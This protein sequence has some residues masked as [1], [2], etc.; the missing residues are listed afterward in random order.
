[1]NRSMQSSSKGTNLEQRRGGPKRLAPEKPSPYHL[2]KQRERLLKLRE[3]VTKEVYQ[4][5][6]EACEEVPNYSMHMAD[7]ATDS[8][9]RDLVLGLASF[10]QEGL[11]EIDAALKR[12][13]DGTYGFC[14]LTGNPISWRRLAALPWTRF[15]LEAENQLEAHIS[16]HLGR[17][18]FIRPSAEE[19][20][21]ASSDS[22]VE[23]EPESNADLDLFLVARRTKAKAPAGNEESLIGDE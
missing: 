10:E 12:I 23:E 7:A 3:E 8:F 1:M 18:H 16:P 20:L 15:S 13:E 5:R 17:L 14:E 21:E 9:D 4:L 19:A 22:V 2:K 11:Y 6:I